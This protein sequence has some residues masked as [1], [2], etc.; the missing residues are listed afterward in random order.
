MQF[1]RLLDEIDVRPDPERV[2]L[3][4]EIMDQFDLFAGFEETLAGMKTQIASFKFSNL[5]PLSHANSQL[6][7]GLRALL[8]Q[9]TRI[10][11][12]KLKPLIARLASYR[13]TNPKV[14]AVID[15]LTEVQGRLTHIEEE[16]V[17]MQQSVI[18]LQDQLDQTHQLKVVPI[19]L[20]QLQ[21]HLEHFFSPV[22]NKFRRIKE[23][24][25]TLEQEVTSNLYT[26]L[27]YETGVPCPQCHYKFLSEK[28]LGDSPPVQTPT[29]R[30]LLCGYI[31]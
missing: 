11:S 10:T 31:A 22:E 13:S 19:D 4:K 21:T 30:C 3:K 28:P 25:T 7:S 5:T 16:V 15:A 14:I 23:F 27:G 24:L 2:D 18:Q 26:K 8:H 9:E 20:S 12:L 1:R 29:V 17:Q 6:L